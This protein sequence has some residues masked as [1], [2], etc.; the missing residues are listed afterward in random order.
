MW[1][2]VQIYSS[3]HATSQAGNIWDKKIKTAK[4]KRKSASEKNVCILL[5][6]SEEGLVSMRACCWG[7]A[8]I[9]ECTKKI[10]TSSP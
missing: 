9:W 5:E 10:A 8:Y 2:E 4:A 3:V 1:M 6:N 7:Y